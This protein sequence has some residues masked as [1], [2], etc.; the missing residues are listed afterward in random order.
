[1]YDF[2]YNYIKAGYGCGTKL[3][4][5]DTNSLVYEIKTDDVYEDFLKIRGLFDFSDYHKHSWFYDPVDKK[6]DW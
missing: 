5:I 2:H 3:L 4:F 6:N 1:M